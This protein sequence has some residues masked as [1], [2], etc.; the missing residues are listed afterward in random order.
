MDIGLSRKFVAWLH[1]YK[2]TFILALSLLANG[3]QYVKSAE[4]R[5]ALLEVQMELQK[6]INET[7]KESLIYERN[8]EDKLDELL[9]ELVRKNLNK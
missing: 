1:K 7:N 8:R 2:Y 9:R 4:E 3:Y 6:T 5:K